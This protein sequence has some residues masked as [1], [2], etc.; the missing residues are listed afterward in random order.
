MFSIKR[1]GNVSSVFSPALFELPGPWRLLWL[2]CLRDARL[3]PVSGIGSEL[4][5]H[6]I[7]DGPSNLAPRTCW[8]SLS[9]LPLL[10]LQ[11]QWIDGVFHE[12]EEG[13]ARRFEVSIENATIRAPWGQANRDDDLLK[14]WDYNFYR[15]RSLSDCWVFET[16]TGDRLVVPGWEVL[17]AW[18]LF[19]P[20]VA[21]AVLAGALDNLEALSHR[22]RPWLPGTKRN[23][24]SSITYGKPRWMTDPVALRTARLIFDPIASR[25]AYDIHRHLMVGMSRLA[26]S[27]ASKTFL[28][29]IKPPCSTAF[30]EW[31]V[32]CKPIS[33]DADGRRR[34]LVLTLE[35][36]DLPLPFDKVFFIDELPPG[37]TGGGRPEKRLYV[38]NRVAPID[39]ASNPDI[40]L[41]AGAPDSSIEAATVL[42][43]GFDDRAI[44]G[45]ETSRH[46]QEGTHG[47]AARVSADPVVISGGATDPA[48]P[49]LR[50]YA[51]IAVEEYDGEPLSVD[52]L[53]RRSIEAFQLLVVET[54]GIPRI[55]RWSAR[56]MANG[57]RDTFAVRS[58]ELE[59]VRHFAILEVKLGPRHFYVLDAQRL[60]G[61]K[62][63]SFAM[64]ICRSDSGYPLAT[65]V[66]RD[67]LSRFPAKTGSPWQGP[68]SGSRSLVH[69]GK[70]VLHQRSDGAL[71]SPRAALDFAI[72]IQGRLTAFAQQ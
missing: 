10:R 26:S 32:R 48:A 47:S 35:G 43:F 38:R 54:P 41:R 45:I 14:P 70:K 9:K 36:A 37:R 55:L 15:Q 61:R 34:W 6:L 3:H 24:D 52:D 67:W 13:I 53:L 25:R 7:P 44:H 20:N 72:H 71:R 17:R 39:P 16:S 22:L 12:A 64:H 19:D 27:T 21:P 68:H 69:D 28:P 49:K 57:N 60:A 11:S 33:A 65:A 8:V 5:A 4:E 56:L 50:G 63:E 23:A 51:R 62:S 2:G 42:G 40:D 59:V 31:D 66:F 18:Y 30:H 1:N 29:M 46:T 58:S